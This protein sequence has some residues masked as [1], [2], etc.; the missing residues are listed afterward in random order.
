MMRKLLT[1]LFFVVLVAAFL[2]TERY[3]YVEHSHSSKKTWAAATDLLEKY[4]IQSENR[5]GAARLFPLPSTDTVLIIDE[6]HTAITDEQIEE[7]HDW[8][9]QGGHLIL[10]A[11]TLYYSED[12]EED[13]PELSDVEKIKDQMNKPDEST[14]DHCKAQ[15]LDKAFADDASKNYAFEDYDADDMKNND[16]LLYSFGATAWHVPRYDAEPMPPAQVNVSDLES[17]FFAP[18]MEGCLNK[19]TQKDNAKAERTYEDCAV[20]LCGDPS[21]NILFSTVYIAGKL[22]QFAFHPEDKL[23]HIDQYPDEEVKRA[24]DEGEY[25][26]ATLPLTDSKI[27]IE[28]GNEFGTQLMQLSY[29]DGTVTAL[30]DLRIWDNQQLPYLDHAWLLHEL[31]DGAPT[32]WWVRHIEMPPIMLWVWIKAWPLIISLIAILCFFLWLK[33]PRRGVQLQLAQHKGRDFLH[34]LYASGFFLWRTKQAGVLLKPLRDQVER[35]LLRHTGANK[36]ATRFK[37]AEKLT[38][39]SAKDIESALTARPSSDADLTFIVNTLQTLRSR[40]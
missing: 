21:L 39:I 1:G 4:G 38:G 14:D 11:R 19:P 28:A 16:A 10:A 29:F 32:V 35:L 3:D 30:T 6:D 13:C 5:Y 37:D 25:E 9:A 15:A 34:H 7:I 36:G 12:D 33:M 8:V 31:T 40:L 20:Q 23:M 26:D 27:R 22:R 24:I 2:V 18:L 17:A